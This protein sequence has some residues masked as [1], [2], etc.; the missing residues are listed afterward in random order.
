MQGITR[1]THVTMHKKEL[2]KI[3]NFTS[4]YLVLINSL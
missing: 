4:Y 2:L 3:S 1:A